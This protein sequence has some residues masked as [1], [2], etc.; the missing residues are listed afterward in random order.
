MADAVEDSTEKGKENETVLLDCRRLDQ[1]HEDLNR[2]G[3]EYTARGEKW[4]EVNRENET[5]IG[6]L[7]PAALVHQELE[8][9]IAT[10]KNQNK[11]ALFPFESYAACPQCKFQRRSSQQAN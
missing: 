6:L 3:K 8:E 5:V 4:D 7:T 2:W 10:L 9:A 11:R 1:R